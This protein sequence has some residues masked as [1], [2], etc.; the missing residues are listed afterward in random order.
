MTNL[1]T[2]CR[3]CGIISKSGKNSCCGRGGSW[4]KN[5]GGAGNANVEH[6]WREGIQVCK[7]WSQSKAA[8]GRQS[9]AAKKLNSSNGVGMANFDA[10][11]TAAT[12][13]FSML[14]NASTLT[15]TTMTVNTLITSSAHTPM[16]NT[17]STVSITAPV[18]TSVLTASTT[19]AAT[20]TAAITRTITTAETTTL[21]S[22]WIS[23]GMHA[24]YVCMS[25]LACRTSMHVLDIY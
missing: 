24:M 21:T 23:Q 3:K 9:S 22:D 16:T 15:P 8:I 14:V 2:A 20:T 10:V 12:S 7:M 19:D 13:I 4:F 11:T 1:S 6:T 17:S 25:H 5:C 18:Y